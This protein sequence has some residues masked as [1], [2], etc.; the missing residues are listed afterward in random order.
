MKQTGVPHKLELTTPS[1]REVRMTRSFDAP[2]ALVFD[3]FTKPELVRRWLLGPD[4]WSMP[5]CEIDL[6]VGGAYHYLWR[7]DEGTREFGV[8]GTYREIARPERILHTERFEGE[9][10]SGEAQVTT[11]FAEIAGTTVVTMTIDYGS[12]EVRDIALES[13]MD[14]GVAASYDRLASILAG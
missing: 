10:D 2:R 1:D 4:G 8:R 6:R 7:N 5:V 13:G 9:L 12:R 3:A 11:T 14:R